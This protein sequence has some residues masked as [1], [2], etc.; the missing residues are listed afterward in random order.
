MSPLDMLDALIGLFFVY[1]VLSLVVT[2]IAEAFNEWTGLRGKNLRDAV[3]RLLQSPQLVERFYAHPRINALKSSDSGR[4]SYIRD[5][6]FA[7]VLLEVV[8]RDRYAELQRQPHR[9]AR[10]I[11]RMGADYDAPQTAR[12]LVSFIEQADGDPARLQAL[13]AQW[14]NDTQER[15]VGWFRRRLTP[16]LLAFGLL[17]T[18]ATNA[19]TLH[20]F[21]V[22]TADDA[23]R[24]AYIASVEQAFDDPQLLPCLGE[25]PPADMDCEWLA[26]AKQQAIQLTPLLGWD[27]PGV[28]QGWAFGLNVI[29]WLL[30]VV[31]LSLGAPFWFD[32]LQKIMRVRGSLRSDGQAGA[33]AAAPPPG[34]TVAAGTVIAPDGSSSGTSLPPFDPDDFT[35]FL[36]AARRHA[37][38][39]A[40]WSVRFAEL[41]YASDA[42]VA[43]RCQSWGLEAESISVRDSGVDTQATIAWSEQVLILVFRGT[44]PTAPGD[45]I[46]DVR[47]Q[48]V[49]CNWSPGIRVHR[50]FQHALDAAWQAIL[51]GI[52]ARHR[53]RPLWLMGHSLGGALAVLAA[54][55]LH[56]EAQDTQGALAG[57]RIA[58]VYTCGQP[59]CGDAAFVEDLE[60]WIGPQWLRI[61]NNRDVVPLVPPPTPGGYAHGGTVLYIDDFGRLIVDPPVWYR[62]LDKLELDPDQFRSRLREAV[63]DHGAASY[64]G[65]LADALQRGQRI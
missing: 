65:W 46:T 24:N 30:T 11:G 5:E 55:R 27:G 39:N 6:L 43:A 32:M 63:G 44:E 29:G 48:L 19:D 61:V 54:H 51:T 33:G 34:G 57:L 40:L 58:G 9:L 64:L 60:T 47:A 38:I 59:R 18:L 50:G 62:S 16:R 4:P 22:L 56:V 53:G 10:E 1:L 14:Y 35:R 31:A 20:I 3:G 36:P 15:A 28:R 26:T 37:L 41:A 49:P 42:E 25:T 23:L 21:S 13:V 8:T 17:V 7:A 52:A 45:I 2:A 12:T